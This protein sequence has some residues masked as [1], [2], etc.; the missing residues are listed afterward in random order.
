MNLRAQVVVIGG[1]TG[2]GIAWHLASAGVR[3]VV[4]VERDELAAGSASKA[5]GGVRAQFSGELDIQL[6][7]RSLEA[8]ARFGEET[9]YD[10]GLHRVGHLCSTCAAPAAG[11]VCTRTPRITTR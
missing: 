1:V 6:G 3:D 5:V 10:I 11:R 8:F 4:L 9:G 2:T 7:A